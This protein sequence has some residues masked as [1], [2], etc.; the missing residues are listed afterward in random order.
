VTADRIVVPAELA[1]FHAKYYGAD[2]KAW[3][4]AL[5][6]LTASFFDRWK[7]RL[8]RPLRHGMVGLIVPVRTADDT[9]ACSAG[10]GRPRAPR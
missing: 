6:E 1:G 3:S 9:L 4:A 2:G 7:L 8:D 5:P 10:P